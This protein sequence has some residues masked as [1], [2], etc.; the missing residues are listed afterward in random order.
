MLKELRTLLSNDTSWGDVEEYESDDDWGSDLR[1]WHQDEI[2]SPVLSIVLRYAPIEETITLLDRFLTL[3][4]NH[5][6]LVYSR[7]SQRTFEP[8][9]DQVVSKLKTTPAFQFLSDPERAFKVATAK[10]SSNLK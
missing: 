2:D 4:E 1:I 10:V 9:W 7:A 5:D 6:M 8:E 3:A